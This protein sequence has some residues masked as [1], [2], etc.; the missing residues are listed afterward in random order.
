MIMSLENITERTFVIIKPDGV[1][2]QNVGE[3]ISRFENKGLKIV[4]LKMLRISEAQAREQ[5][6]CHKG[7]A[8][9]DSLVEFI[10]SGP[11]VAVVLEGRNAISITRKLMGATD[12]L[13][14]E[15]GT[16]RGDLSLD[17]KHNL[18][19]GS[20]SQDSFNHEMP[21]YFKPNELLNYDIPIKDW[22]YYL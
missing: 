3:I 13:A 11:S 5:Y 1:H 7:K 19:H 20:D 6:A 22:L 14:A 15:P 8:F 17:I 4:G 12:P 18:V 16:I 2:R 10:T 9:Y 21:I